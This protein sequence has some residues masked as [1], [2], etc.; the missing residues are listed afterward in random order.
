MKKRKTLFYL[1]LFFIIFVSLGFLLF[2]S[3]NITKEELSKNYLEKQTSF[4]NEIKNKFMEDL[5][6]DIL[7]KNTSSTDYFVVVEDFNVI[8]RNTK[9]EN[10]TVYNLISSFG[11]KKGV[12]VF[13]NYVL[14]NIDGCSSFYDKDGIF[15]GFIIKNFIIEDKQFSLIYIVDTN[16]YF[17]DDFNSL[18]YICIFSIL[19]I[20]V[21]FSWAVIIIS[22]EV[23]VNTQ[24]V[25]INN[26]SN[27]EYKTTI[28]EDGKEDLK[29]SKVYDKKFFFDIVDKI[30]SDSKYSNTY[31]IYFKIYGIGN[32]VRKNNIEDRVCKMIEQSGNTNSFIS[33]L[34]DNK[35]I[36]TLVNSSSEEASRVK[37]TYQDMFSKEFDDS[38]FLHIYD[39]NLRT[40]L[41]AIEDGD[42]NI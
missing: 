42:I 7:D 4:V 24:T 6:F 3:F 19:F 28:G 13:E 40:L 31:F 9:K 14:N 26:M 32:S 38:Y 35:Y 15:R 8:Y 41:Y 16:S 23:K 39:L 21:L 37:E 20:Y 36:I 30:K 17:K 27:K 29:L 22:K 34:D 18:F 1:L 2:F 33:S 25:Y 5:N 12:D 10:F 11:D